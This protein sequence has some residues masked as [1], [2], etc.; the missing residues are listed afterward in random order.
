M[1]KETDSKKSETAAPNSLGPNKNMLWA[2]TGAL[3]LMFVLG[4]LIV[5]QLFAK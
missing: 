5:W 2:L 4:G 3:V 1:A